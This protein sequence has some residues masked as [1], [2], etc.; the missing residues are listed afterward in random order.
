MCSS[1][2]ASQDLRSQL[3]IRCARAVVGKALE[4]AG[5]HRV[6]DPHT[7]GCTP[8]GQEEARQQALSKVGSQPVGEVVPRWPTAENVQR[9]HR[10]LRATLQHRQCAVPGALDG[11][12]SVG[13]SLSDPVCREDQHA[14][15]SAKVSR[16]FAQCLCA[17]CGWEIG[18]A[19]V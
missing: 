16:E 4:V 13:W 7:D 2:L 15:A 6:P 12:A 9:Q 11:L 1:D 5:W 10:C 17:M 3:Q 8:L 19:H 14:S 18:R